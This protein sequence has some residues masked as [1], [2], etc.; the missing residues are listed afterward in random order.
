VTVTTVPPPWGPVAGLTAVTVGA[1]GG[2]QL[3]DIPAMGEGTDSGPSPVAL[4]AWTLRWY[5]PS[6][7]SSRCI[8]SRGGLIAGQVDESVGDDDARQT[9]FEASNIRT[10]WLVSAQPA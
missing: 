1:G 3:V 6:G 9:G 8:D 10:V 4:V 7:T 5:V 2:G